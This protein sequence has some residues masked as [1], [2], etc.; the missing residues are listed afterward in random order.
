MLNIPP[1]VEISQDFSLILIDLYV[2][3]WEKVKQYYPSLHPMLRFL[4]D[5]HS[6]HVEANALISSSML[7]IGPKLL[8]AQDLVH[9][10]HSTQDE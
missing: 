3:H 9:L 4:N 1:L 10:L 6:L 2:S 5:A 7:F 8:V